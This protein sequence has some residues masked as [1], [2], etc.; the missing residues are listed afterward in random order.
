MMMKKNIYL[1]IILVSGLVFLGSCEKKTSSEDTSRITYYVT[2]ELDG[3]SLVIIPAG[4]TYVEPGYTAMEGETDVTA[5]VDV[6]SDLDESTP[7]YYTIVY[8]AINKDGFSA[9]VQRNVV[10]YDPASPDDDFSGSYITDII[11]TESD[12]SDPRPYSG[13]AN[14]TKVAQGVFYVDCLLGGTYSIG[15]GYGPAYA[16]TGYIKLEADYSITLLSSYVAGWGDGLEGFQN[17]EYDSGTGFLY[18]ESIY[19]SGDIYAVTLN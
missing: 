2:F 9:A 19:A 13:A 3:P 16:M 8:S 6:S 4:G 11:R 18:W 15:Y 1:L 14:I 17:G 7:G 10:V 5:D 12:G